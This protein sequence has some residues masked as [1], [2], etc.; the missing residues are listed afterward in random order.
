M[1]KRKIEERLRKALLQ[2][3]NME[4]ALYEFE[5]E[6][7]RD[8][9]Y[10]GLQNDGDEFVFAVTENSGDVAMVLITEDKTVY[11]NEEAREKLSELWHQAYRGNMERLIPVMA[12]EL[13]DGMITVSGVKTVLRR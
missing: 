6:E 1:S 4:H 8:Y 12:Q 11:V 10:Q 2:D 7:H 13:A 9:W 3:G 5:L